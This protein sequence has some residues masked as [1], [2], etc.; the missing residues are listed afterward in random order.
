MTASQGAAGG[1]TSNPRGS[2]TAP[3]INQAWARF[4]ANGA[5]MT[6]DNWVTIALQ[7]G[8]AAMPD[9][10]RPFCRPPV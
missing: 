8:P 2:N 5:G 10:Y 9:Q 6:P 4:C 3:E 7:G 1:P